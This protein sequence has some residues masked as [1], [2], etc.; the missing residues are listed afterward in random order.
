M[1][2]HGRSG[3][4]LRIIGFLSDVW[5]F[6]VQHGRGNDEADMLEVAARGVDTMKRRHPDLWKGMVEVNLAPKEV[7]D[8]IVS[9]ALGENDKATGKAGTQ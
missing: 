1:V 6:Q 3:Y 8:I 9:V 7:A 2:A 4:E 5:P